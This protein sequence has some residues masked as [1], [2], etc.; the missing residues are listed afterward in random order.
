[1][2]RRFR[3]KRLS[4]VFGTGLTQPL[5]MPSWKE[6][7]QLIADDPTVKG[8]HLLATPTEKTVREQLNNDNYEEVTRLFGNVPEETIITQRLYEHFKA[9]RHESEPPDPK[10]ILEWNAD[11]QKEWRGIIREK[12]YGDSIKLKP[13]ALAPKILSDH[14]YLSR[15]MPI[16]QIMPLTIT[17]NFDDIL[18]IALT[19][20]SNDV[21]EILG[22]KYETTTDISKP[23]RKQ[24][25]VIYHPNGYIPRNKMEGRSEKIVLSEDEFA[26][27]MIETMTGQYASLSHHFQR[28][29][30]IFIGLSLKDNILKNLLRQSAQVTPGHYHYYIYYY[31]ENK[32]P[33]K[34]EQHAICESNFAVYNLITLFLSGKE[35]AALGKLITDG[36][37]RVKD[38]EKGEVDDTSFL[39]LA[40]DVGV[41]PVY[42][43]YIVG[44]VGAGKSTLVSHF[45]DLETHDEWV[46]DRLPELAEV[47]GREEGVG[48]EMI[49]QA[50]AKR[51]HI[52]DWVTDQFARK[53]I[54]LWEESVGIVVSDRCPLDPLAFTHR[55]ERRAKAKLII[56]KIRPEPA[57][58]KIREGQVIYLQNDPRALE[59]RIR[60]TDKKYRKPD[61]EAMQAVLEDIYSIPGSSTIKTA[62][63]SSFDIIQRVAYFIWN[64]MIRL[65]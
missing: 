32:K 3:D 61:L 10:H 38:K 35:I 9:N 25:G 65:I 56:S 51:E 53:N 40:G 49:R 29:S 36:H 19:G 45:R 54:I 18:E 27:R 20:S 6:L 24:S 28:S 41:E 2:R 55:S 12:L 21:D 42:H 13:E 57:E 48:A 15:L 62:L 34:I 63:M 47:W 43:Y 33:S 5:G 50:R 4:L 31:S 14:P 16:I 22:R 26:G 44:A 7:N 59:I 11:N 30:C 17:Y 64:H 39:R 37:S 1:M 8:S 52:D 60:T 46:E 23:S 58:T